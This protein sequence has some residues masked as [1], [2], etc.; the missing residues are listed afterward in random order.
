MQ[1]LLAHKMEKEEH[2]VI[3]TITHTRNIMGCSENGFY[4]GTAK[5]TDRL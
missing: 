1:D 3:S 5:N 4:I 2:R